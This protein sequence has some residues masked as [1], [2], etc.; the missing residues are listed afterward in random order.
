MN[1]SVLRAVDLLGPRR[2]RHA[3]SSSARSPS[4]WPG[5]RRL[6]DFVCAL[7][8]AAGVVSCSPGRTARSTRWHRACAHRRRGV[9]RLHPADPPGRHPAAGP[10][11]HHHRERRQPRAASLPL[12]L[13]TVDYSSSTGASSACSSRSG[14]SRRRSLTRWTPSS[15]AGSPRASTRSSRASARSSPPCSA[16]WCSARPCTLQQQIAIVLVCA[17]AGAAIATQRRERPKTD[18]ERTADAVT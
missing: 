5:S 2:G 17:A 13:V 16:H 9:G 14:C 15:C 18:L 10:G 8:A 12:A 4:R 6:L 3:S 1:L 11:G 7:A